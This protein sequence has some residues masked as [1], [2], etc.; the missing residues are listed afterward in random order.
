MPGDATARGQAVILTLATSARP[1]PMAADQA[2]TLEVVQHVVDRATMP[3]DGVLRLY[4]DVL[5]DLVS[6][7]GPP[8][9]RIQHQQIE[10]PRHQ[11]FRKMVDLHV[12]IDVTD[13]YHDSRAVCGSSA[14][15]RRAE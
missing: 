12:M 10:R 11:I 2:L 14:E 3:A 15:A 8:A 7:G 4:A 9:Q 5:H 13:T 6:V 1:L